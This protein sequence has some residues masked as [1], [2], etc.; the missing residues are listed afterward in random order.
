MTWPRVAR[1]E[2][3]Q[4]WR[5]RVLPAAAVVLGTLVLGAAVAGHG[6]YAT[7]EA[8]RRRYQQ[9]VADQWQQQPDRHPHRVS[10]YGFLVFRP[11]S[12]LGFIDTGVE[13]FTGTSLFLEAHRQNSANFSDASQAGGASRFGELTVAMVLQALVPLLVFAVAGVSVTREREAGTLALLLCQGLSW[14]QLLA[15]KLAGTLAAVALVLVP[16]VALTVPWATAGTGTWSA[17][18]LT[19]AALLAAAH[20]VYLVACAGL[21]LLLSARH[22][23]SR[24]A[25]ATLVALWVA[26]WVV[27]PRVLPGVAAAV[28]PVPVRAEFE[29]RVERHVRTLGD[30]H[31]PGDPRFRQ[32]QAD[33]LK[34]YGAATV[35]DLPINYN[36]LVMAEGERLTTEAYRRFR[37]ELLDTYARQARLVELGGLVSPFLA[38]RSVSMALAGVDVA[39][40]VEFERQAEDYRYALIQALNDLHV[41]EVEY[42]RDRYVGTGDAAVPS[43]QRIDQA[44]FQGIPTFAHDAPTVGWALAGQPIGLAA[45]GAWT[46]GILS[47]LAAIGR[48]APIL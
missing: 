29:A 39:H 9:L 15:G 43:R 4:A 45:L 42:G 7:E 48:R 31:D 2:L 8:Q 24:G 26:L 13:R 38:M 6:R 27:L 44:H 10:H 5:A 40:A 21:A 17:D 37:G 14:P 25:L 35:A 23:T 11:P 16:G 30:S 1:H 46:L 20:A 28:Y 41:H 12:P 19:R 3:R 18:T 22:R 32:L 33:T 47:A 34:K 36:G